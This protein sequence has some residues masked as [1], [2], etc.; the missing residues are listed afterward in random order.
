MR[1]RDEP[2]ATA[3]QHYWKTQ[4]L[5]SSQAARCHNRDCEYWDQHYN[6]SDDPI[7]DHLRQLDGQFYFVWASALCSHLGRAEDQ[8]L[9]TLCDR[10]MC[11]PC[12]GRALYCIL[13]TEYIAQMCMLDSE[14]AALAGLKDL[15]GDPIVSLKHPDRRTAHVLLNDTAYCAA[16]FMAGFTGR[17]HFTQL[18]ILL[19]CGTSFPV[20]SAD[21]SEV[22]YNFSVISTEFSG[23][24]L[25][26][27]AKAGFFRPYHSFSLVVRHMSV[28]RLWDLVAFMRSKSVGDPRR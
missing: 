5:D 6:S 3:R 26:K 13:R 25:R 11:M 7:L 17:P 18:A 1:H 23:D 14:W 27:R 12:F 28:E 4:L 22:R 24:M 16:R 10:G 21:G 8:A 9:Q 20:S 19:N 15:R 2:L